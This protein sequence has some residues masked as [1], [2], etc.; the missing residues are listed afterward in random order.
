CTA[1]PRIR[2]PAVHA[3]VG[4]VDSHRIDWR[5]G[6]AVLHDPVA[7][8]E[9]DRLVD[10]TGGHVV[11]VAPNAGAKNRRKAGA[12]FSHFCDP[13]DYVDCRP[14]LVADEF[15]RRFD[16]KVYRRGATKHTTHPTATR[17]SQKLAHRRQEST[18]GLVKGEC[19]SA[20]S[21]SKHAAEVEQFGAGCTFDGREHRRHHVVIPR[22]V[23]RRQYCNGPRW[24]S[25]TARTSDL[26]SWRRDSPR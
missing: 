4:Y 3:V 20:W 14:N 15:I 5:V 2:S 9:P 8:S 12:E 21:D 25:F 10:H 1:G 26:L 17:G 23:H 7:V 22:L 16:S 24:S 13:G 11:S 19:R 6:G 18:R